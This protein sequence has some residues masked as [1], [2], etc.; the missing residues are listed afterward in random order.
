MIID[1]PEYRAA[2]EEL[3]SIIV[4]NMV[5]IAVNDMIGISRQVIESAHEALEAGE[6][7]EEQMSAVESVQN[8]YNCLYDTLTDSYAEH[9]VPD[10]LEGLDDE[11]PG[12]EA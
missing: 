1:N 8:I 9:L 2:V 10:D 4:D 7:T 12:Q 11:F 5:F 6:I 3:D